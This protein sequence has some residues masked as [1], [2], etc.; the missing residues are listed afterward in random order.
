M[1]IAENKKPSVVKKHWGKLL[2][3]SAVLGIGGGALLDNHKKPIVL[4]GSSKIQFTEKERKAIQL[5]MDDE[6]ETL[7]EGGV[8][9]FK[10]NDIGIE[11]TIT[12][13]EL[14]K[15][16]HRNEVAAD[17]DF[18]DKTLLIKGTVTSID[19]DFADNVILKLQGKQLFM[20]VMAY[21]KETDIADVAHMQ[22][23]QKIALVC[24]GKGMVIGNAVVRN[25]RQAQKAVGER[26]IK[27]VNASVSEENQDSPTAR[28]IGVGKYLAKSLSPNS[29]CWQDPSSKECEKE[30]EKIFEKLKQ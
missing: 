14:S 24:E 27:M 30:L 16:Y 6:V 26:L 18:R 3:A 8:G 5:L 9:D 29:S 1:S 4:E 13:I 28:L 12:A 10:L 23:G 11:Q 2:L 19:K 25:C 15:A 21:M 22:K 20:G 7:I 17:N